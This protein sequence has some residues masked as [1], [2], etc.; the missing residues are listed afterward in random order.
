MSVTAMEHVW[1]HHTAGPPG[2]YQEPQYILVDE[3]DHWPVHAGLATAAPATATEAQPL[4][5]LPGVAAQ[6]PGKPV[7]YGGEAQP[8]DE[9]TESDD[10]YPAL[11]WQHAAA[12]QLQRRPESALTGASAQPS[13]TPSVSLAAGPTTAGGSTT[14]AV[15]TK[16]SSKGGAAP[17]A[18]KPGGKGGITLRLLIE[19]GILQP[20]H[21]VLSVVRDAAL[22]LLVAWC[23]TFLIMQDMCRQAALLLSRCKLC[24]MRIWHAYLAAPG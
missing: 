21:N 17:K 13:P 11:A 7:L 20:G 23:F 22:K 6:P 15:G 9:A 10:E 18:R 12:P 4:P 5:P 19:E 1:D 14:G 8:D 16:S 2:M 24:G 3:H